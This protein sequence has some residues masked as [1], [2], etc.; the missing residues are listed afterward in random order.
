MPYL[1][2]Y[3]IVAPSGI[4]PDTGELWCGG[5]T[6][7]LA[8]VTSTTDDLNPAQDIDAWNTYVNTVADTSTLTGV[9][10]ADWKVIG[11]SMAVNARDNALVTAPVNR[12]CC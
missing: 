10:D 8:F 3:G 7:H 9:P 5:D 12:P 2:R 11:S 4:N 6:Y 1:I